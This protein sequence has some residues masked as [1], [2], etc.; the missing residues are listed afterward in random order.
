MNYTHKCIF[1]VGKLY[2]A[3]FSQYFQVFFSKGQYMVYNICFC[4]IF[5]L[6]RCCSVPLKLY[7]ITVY[8][9]FLLEFYRLDFQRLLT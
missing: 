3:P 7:N 9:M 5:L 6:L 2:M 1:A 4:C 8:E